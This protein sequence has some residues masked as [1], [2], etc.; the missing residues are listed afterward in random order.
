MTVADKI[1]K[2]YNALINRINEKINTHNSD[3]S[4]HSTEMSKKLNKAQ[5]SSNASKNVVTDSSG[6]ITTES[7]ITKVSD[8]SNDAG[9]LTSIGWG[10]IT[11]KPFSSVDSALSN[12]STNPVQNYAI[13]NE[14]DNKINKTDFDVILQDNGYIKIKLDNTEET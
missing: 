4:A 13:K 12:S 6:N 5:G 1:N 3:S 7:K 10:Q 8:L 2:V 14:L 9:Y 11:S